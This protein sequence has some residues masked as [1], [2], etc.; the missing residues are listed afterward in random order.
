MKKKKAKKIK[1]LVISLCLTIMF[2]GGIVAFYILN[3]INPVLIRI[4]EAKAS[5]MLTIAV[6]RAVYSVLDAEKYE[7][8]I[9]VHKDNSGNITLL[10]ANA[11]KINDIAR[12]T[13]QTAQ[14]EIDMIG[15]VSINVPLGSATG[16]PL[17]IGIGPDIDLNILP[18]GKAVCNFKSDFESAGINQTRHKIYIEVNADM[19]LALPISKKQISSTVEIFITETILVGD[20]PQL[21]LKFDTGEN[22]LFVP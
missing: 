18:I 15:I 11:L 20:V 5:A 22:S 1:K 14:R 10:Q 12:N 4:A 7:D 19:E 16:A 6:N 13:A 2:M 3:V 8:L 17:L 9:S 21:Y